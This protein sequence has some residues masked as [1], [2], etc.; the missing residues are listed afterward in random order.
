MT[1]EHDAHGNAVD[2]TWT[3]GNPALCGADPGQALAV[4]PS[5]AIRPDELRHSDRVA[6]GLTDGHPDPGYDPAADD[7][8]PAL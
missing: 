2:P 8:D 1:V 5:P 4:P 6:Q 3:P 7:L